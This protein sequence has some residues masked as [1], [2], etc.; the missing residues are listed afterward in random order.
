MLQ[1]ADNLEEIVRLPARL[2]TAINM[3]RRL[4]D[5]QLVRQELVLLAI[6]TH[7]LAEARRHSKI[8]LETGG[9]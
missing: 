5:V 7:D 6:E 1:S 9:T 2:V 4:R 8:L 3:L